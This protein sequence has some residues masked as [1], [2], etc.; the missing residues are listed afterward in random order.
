MTLD[1]KILITDMNCDEARLFFLK[2][3]SYFSVNL[4][5]YFNF[6][7]LLDYSINLIGNERLNK[8]THLLQIT[9]YSKVPDINYILQMNKTKESFR[10]MSL[11]HPLLYVDLVNLL[12]EENNWK[13]LIDRYKKLKRCVQDRITCESIPFELK[14]NI[15]NSRY[16]FHFWERI[17][18]ESLI[19]SLEYNKLLS[20][21]IS[22][23]YGSI[24]THIIPWAIHGEEEAKD[25]RGNS[26]LGNEIDKT[27]RCMNYGETVGIPQGNVISD[28]ISELILVY[29]DF[30]LYERLNDLN[31]EYKI[32]RYR[33]DYRIFTL[34]KKTENIIKK[35]LVLILQ[36]HKLALGESKTK[37]SSE[38]IL[39]S[40]KQDKL[41]WIEQNPVMTTKIDL[42]RKET[43]IDIEEFNHFIPH[44]LYKTSI[45]KHLL[46]IKMFADKF[47]NSGQLIKAISDFEYRVV[48]LTSNDLL[49]N[50]TN[51]SVLIAIVFNLIENNPKII[52][53]GV[54]LLSILFSKEI[55][56]PDMFEYFINIPIL[57]NDTINKKFERINSIIKRIATH[58]INS[59]LEIWLQ[60]LV[61]KVLK[62]SSSFT[63]DY[64]STSID[65]FVKITN[66]VIRNDDISTVLFNEEWIHEKYRIN[67]LEFIDINEIENLS[68][69]IKI[70]EIKDFEYSNF[71]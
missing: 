41:Y 58:S 7:Y 19:L 12:T 70:D 65:S 4:P 69:T 45:Q 71:I 34:D 6:N 64:I 1:N 29:L 46:I 11:I 37:S 27:F 23:F 47:P 50:G 59:Y 9:K 5:T 54:K 14:S 20:V 26:L 16:A 32:L 62:E 60:R 66:D 52:A 24:Y 53:N 63:N 57:K 38:I 22:N 36:R 8:K 31:L 18:Q 44:K 51:I 61:I 33:D 28:F 49:N 43:D 30:L 13:E 3:D 2:K 10:P 42:K 56:E 21:D 35:E 15:D 55:N 17:E 40:I 68:D 25:N 67:W 39:D 48:D